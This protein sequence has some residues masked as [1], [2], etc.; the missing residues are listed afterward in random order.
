MNINHSVFNSCLKSRASLAAPGPISLQS[1]VSRA[2][3]GK[4]RCVR[5][6]VATPWFLVKDEG[7]ITN[8]P[9]IRFWRLRGLIDHSLT[10]ELT[11]D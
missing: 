10:I 3:R 5:K 11:E 4:A 8:S 6:G 7:A 2:A 1:I 9:K